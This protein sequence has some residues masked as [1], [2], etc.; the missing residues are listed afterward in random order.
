[1]SGGV[2]ASPSSAPG[3]IESRRALLALVGGT[4]PQAK[5][6]ADA[7]PAIAAM[8]AAH[9]LEPLLAWQAERGGWPVPEAVAET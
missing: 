8:A 5:I 3:K 2:T 4:W 9:R 1:M 6:D 7:W